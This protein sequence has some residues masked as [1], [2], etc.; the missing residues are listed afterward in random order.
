MNSNI[1]DLM[2]KIKS[3]VLLRN[4][5]YRLKTKCIRRDSNKV[6]GNDTVIAI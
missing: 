6:V 4:D 2:F 3:R 1:G 5:N